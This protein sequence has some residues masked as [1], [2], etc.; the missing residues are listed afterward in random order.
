MRAEKPL[1]LNQGASLFEDEPL[2]S[3]LNEHT[4]L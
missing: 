1:G 4:F 3:S 2:C